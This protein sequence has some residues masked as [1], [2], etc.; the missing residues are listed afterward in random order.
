MAFDKL[1]DKFSF[2]QNTK[3]LITNNAFENACR[4]SNN[5]LD[6]TDHNINY[7]DIYNFYS[8]DSFLDRAICRYRNVMIY[9]NDISLS[10][11][12][13]DHSVK[14]E[15]I[16]ERNKSVC[17]IVLGDDLLSRQNENNIEQRLSNSFAGNCARIN[18]SDLYIFQVKD[19]CNTQLVFKLKKVLENLKEKEYNEIFIIFQ[20]VDPARCFRS[21]FWKPYNILTTSLD[22]DLEILKNHPSYHLLGHHELPK[23]YTDKIESFFNNSLIFSLPNLKYKV[24]PI[25]CPFEFYQL[26]EW[27]IL[28]MI[29][30]VTKIKRQDTTVK[31]IVWKDFYK[32]VY[33]NDKTFLHSTNL[34]KFKTKSD[35]LPIDS[36]GGRFVLERVKES[37]ED[38]LE[39]F[40]DPEFKKFLPNVIYNPLVNI[41]DKTQSLF[42]TQQTIDYKTQIDKSIYF[43]NQDHKDWADL[44]CSGW[45]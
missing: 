19:I 6:N 16:L 11:N 28:E 15:I 41:N 29:N 21:K 25:L 22:L 32:P 12:K 2:F 43:T 26:Y 8:A 42:T 4:Q 33:T 9:N 24:L 23:I 36:N 18:D 40:W 1:V 5:E 3:K 38:N 45:Q 7:R 20:M 39:F 17:T 30:E 35:K 31:H 34:Y 10:Y 14:N 44:L 13:K 37:P 27:S